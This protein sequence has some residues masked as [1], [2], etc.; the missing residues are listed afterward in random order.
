LPKP[1]IFD[2]PPSKPDDDFWLEQGRKLVD[3]SMAA[4]KDAAKNLLTGLGALQ[5]IYIAMLG[6]A[7][8]I[9]KTLDVWTKSLFFIPM[10]CWMVAIYLALQVL[11][12]RQLYIY[13]HS[14]EDIQKE[15][16]EMVE[17]RQKHLQWAFWSATAGLVAVAVLLLYRLSLPS[18]APPAPLCPCLSWL[19]ESICPFFSLTDP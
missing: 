11:M 16:G 1:I 14:P 10:L 12:T 3:G 8:F 9:P 19:E 15:L 17:I 6:F 18:P 2:S 7:E 13:L 5:G 4:V